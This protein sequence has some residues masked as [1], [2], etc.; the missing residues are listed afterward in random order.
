[1]VS[2]PIENGVVF[3]HNFFLL[4]CSNLRAE[5]S[6]LGKGHCGNKLEIQFIH[7]FRT[8]ILES[9]MEVSEILDIL[10]REDDVSVGSFSSECV[11]LIGPSGAVE[12]EEEPEKEFEEVS[13]RAKL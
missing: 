9:S 1:M 12:T 13:P 5:T 6:L 7:L 11:D 10:D 3:C 8:E 4:S 2:Q